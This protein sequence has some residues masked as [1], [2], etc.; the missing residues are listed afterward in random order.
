LIT[1]SDRVEAATPSLSND[2]R[3]L[4]G[5]INDSR[6]TF[7]PTDI[8]AAAPAVQEL[9]TQSP[10]NNK[11]IIVLSDLARH[12]FHGDSARFPERARVIACAPQ[13]TDNQWIN[14]ARFEYD[15]NAREWQIDTSGQASGRTV[16]KWPVFL[17]VNDTKKGNDRAMFN[18][19]GMF[20][21]RFTCPGDEQC[22]N[23][24]VRLAPDNLLADNCF[25]FSARRPQSYKIWII[26]GDYRFGGAAA[27]SF[28]LRTVFPRA[29]VLSESGIATA[30]FE[31]PGILVLANIREDDP[32]IEQAVR[33]GCGAIVFLGEHSADAFNP[34]Y[35]PASIGSEFNEVQNVRWAEESHPIGTN[36]PIR[37]FD[38][39]KTAVEKGYILKAKEQSKTLATLSSG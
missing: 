39:D 34:L 11:A 12:G 25:Y 3:Y 33:A 5:L 20:I 24:S 4:E 28:Y 38:W 23:G 35:L 16:T 31:P 21:H 1:Y 37:E 14:E 29:E 32:K 6:A 30:A 17:Y 27:E 15:E 18:A 2:R 22:L 8:A 9:L 26:D 13:T 36:L 7:R 19:R 10:G